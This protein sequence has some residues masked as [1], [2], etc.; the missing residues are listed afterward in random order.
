MSA[1]TWLADGLKGRHVLLA[2]VGFFGVMFVVN[3]IFVYYALTTFGGGETTDPYRK[4]LNYN[5]TLAE[6]ARQDQQGWRVQVIYGATAGRLAFNLSDSEGRP[7]SGLHFT[8][9][10]SRPVTDREDIPAT[11]KEVTSGTY[12]ANLRLAPGQWVIQLH[13][14]ELSRDGAPS[15]R[16][17]QRL[18]VAEAP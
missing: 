15:Y 11:F 18:F 12:T 14:E 6:A 13:S 9:T 2:L 8:G 17:K 16:L 4:G 7:V 1:T 10:L 5:E 3:G